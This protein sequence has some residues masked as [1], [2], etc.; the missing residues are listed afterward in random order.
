MSKFD[1]VAAYKQV[2]CKVDDI[3]LQFLH[4]FF[5]LSNFKL[6]QSAYNYPVLS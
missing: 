5:K 1:L 2:P 6:I 4:N 3:R